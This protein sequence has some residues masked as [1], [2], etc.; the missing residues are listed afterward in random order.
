M[1]QKRK[2]LSHLR[3]PEGFRC[4]QCSGGK[5]WPVRDVLLECSACGAQSA[6]AS[7]HMQCLRIHTQSHAPVLWDGVPG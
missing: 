2:Y 6:A 1:N 5:E 7:R 3:W 4:P